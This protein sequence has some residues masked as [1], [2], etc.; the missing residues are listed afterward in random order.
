MKLC[1][2]LC[3]LK[4]NLIVQKKKLFCLLSNNNYLHNSQGITLAHP[5]AHVGPSQ[6]M[7]TAC[8]VCMKAKRCPNKP[9]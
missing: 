7:T 1:Y 4:E 5:Y 9:L 2:C 3:F 8:R 6:K